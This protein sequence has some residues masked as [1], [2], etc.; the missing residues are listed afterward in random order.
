M[1]QSDRKIARKGFQFKESN[2][3]RA[4]LY[5]LNNSATLRLR[6]GLIFKNVT[7]KT[8]RIVLRDLS[9]FL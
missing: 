6:P 9:T 7:C 2:C 8:Q 5:A 4:H 1:D 3:K